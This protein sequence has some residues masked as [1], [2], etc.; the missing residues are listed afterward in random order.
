MMDLTPVESET[1]GLGCPKCKNPLQLKVVV[2]GLGACGE[3]GARV[4]VDQRYRAAIARATADRGQ[5][6]TASWKDIV[7]SDLLALFLFFLFFIPGLRSAFKK[8]MP[9]QFAST[10]YYIGS[11]AGLILAEPFSEPMFLPWS[12]IVGWSFR[13]A[14]EDMNA[15]TEIHYATADSQTATVSLQGDEYAE[16]CDFLNARFPDRAVN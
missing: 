1:P 5:V 16:I 6:Q 15:L 2:D 3:C 11:S 9:N 13:T 12:S 8:L 14:A 7:R 10:L 4:I